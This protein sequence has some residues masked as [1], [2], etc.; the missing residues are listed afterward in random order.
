[1]RSLA[2]PRPPEESWGGWRCPGLMGEAEEWGWSLSPTANAHGGP[3]W[4]LS[5]ATHVIQFGA[6]WPFGRMVSGAAWP[7]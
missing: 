1:M 2:L 7:A 5:Q 3:S 6:A 4:P